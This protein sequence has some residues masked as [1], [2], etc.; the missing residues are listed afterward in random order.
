MAYQAHTLVT[1][2]GTL[3]E[4]SAADEIWQCGIRGFNTGGG[5]V[6]QGAL[7]DLALAILR[8][9]TGVG[10]GL[11]GVF[12]TDDGCISSEARLNWCKAVNIQADG[13]YAGAPGIAEIPGGVAGSRSASVPSFCSV[14]ITWTTGA[15]FGQA[16][17]GRIYL[18]NYGAHLQAGSVVAAAD[19]ALIG[20]FGQDI[21]HS[22]DH[23]SA[24]DGYDFNPYVVSRS[25]VSRPIS[26]IRVGNV[27]DTQTRRKDA[28]PET[29]SNFALTGPSGDA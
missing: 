26:G 15:T 1:F 6:P 21:L 3:S 24:D 11:E 5:P 27:F 20:A 12:S 13:T 7:G 19:V 25:G 8:G 29:Y 22:V 18:P 23:G 16:R 4:K 10:G 17:T 14:A 2:G 9:P 28:V